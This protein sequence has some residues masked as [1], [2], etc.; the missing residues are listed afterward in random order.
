MSML[1]CVPRSLLR[2][3][4]RCRGKWLCVMCHRRGASAA[5]L[6]SNVLPGWRLYRNGKLVQEAMPEDEETEEDEEKEAPRPRKRRR[7]GQ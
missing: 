5:R 4:Q 2:G 6:H 1:R 3:H 7:G